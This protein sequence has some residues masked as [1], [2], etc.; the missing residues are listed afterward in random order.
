MMRSGHR[1]V[2][3]IYSS[4]QAGNPHHF[5]VVNPLE[6]HL[7]VIKRDYGDKEKIE[8]KMEG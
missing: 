7:C 1:S 5:K 6:T 4:T 3:I 8:K 2:V